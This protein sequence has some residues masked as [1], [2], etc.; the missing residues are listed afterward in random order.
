MNRNT[1]TEWK[2]LDHG[3]L[4][5]L[6]SNL[7]RVEGALPDMALP[8]HM[9]IVKLPGERL[10]IHN[11]IAVGDE[12]REQIEQLGDPTYLLVPNGWHRLDA[13]AYKQRYPELSVICPRGSRDKVEE[14]VAVDLTYDQFSGEDAV[15]LVHLDGLRDVEGVLQYRGEDGVT[16][17]FNDVLFN[18]PHM[19]GM[20]G[21][22]FRLIGS[23]GGP[24]V[25]RIARWGIVK[26]RSACADH[27][28]RLAR[29]VGLVRVI[30]GHGEL[31]EDDAPQVLAQVADNL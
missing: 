10:L 27:I 11:A 15:S 20:M 5:Q 17:V 21:L 26:D 16:L 29:T 4:E 1:N 19:A 3:T 2:V 6:T 31:I 7:Y 22:F 25:T 24:K 13:P 28:G 9:I 12:V 8:R 18:Q 30:P 14:A 23:T